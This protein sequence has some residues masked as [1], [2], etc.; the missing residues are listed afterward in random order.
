MAAGDKPVP[1]SEPPNLSLTESEVADL[2]ET[3]AREI[4]VPQRYVV[5]YMHL[6]P[7]AAQA[8]QPIFVGGTVKSGTVIVLDA[9]ILDPMQHLNAPELA[10]L[11]LRARIEV[12]LV[13][14]LAERNYLAFHGLANASPASHLAAINGGAVTALRISEETRRFLSTWAAK[15]REAGKGIPVP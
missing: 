6:L 2:A 4:R 5:E 1:G 14:E 13:H 7:E 9:G 8:G 11:S 10:R 15:S 3:V 12:V